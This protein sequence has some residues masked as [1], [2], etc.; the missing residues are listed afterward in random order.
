MCGRMRGEHETRR[1]ALLRELHELEAK[2][3]PLKCALTYV[4]YASPSASFCIQSFIQSYSACLHS[5]MQMW[6]GDREGEP[7]PLK[8]QTPVHDA[9]RKHIWRLLQL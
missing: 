3:N 9:L 8:T 4:C 2:L 5:S 1:E 6:S 7:S